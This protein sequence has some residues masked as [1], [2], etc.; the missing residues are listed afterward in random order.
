[1]FDLL[2]KNGKIID[3][4][5]AEP[6][7]A[8]VGIKD[9][10]ILEIG[11]SLSGAVSEI[12]ATGLVVTPGFIDSHSHSDNAV[13]SYPDMIDRLIELAF[14]RERNRENLTFTINTNILSGAKLGS[15]GSKGA[16]I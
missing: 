3:G 15:K 4:T 11:K 13:L 2:I 1:M 9:G 5:G 6:Y 16:K 8:D 7:L 10:K 12:D 14:R